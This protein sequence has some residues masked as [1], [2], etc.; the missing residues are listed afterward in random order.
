MKKLALI[1]FLTACYVFDPPSDAYHITR[2]AEYDAWWVEV[3]KCSG[4]T[5]D[6]NRVN[7]N[8][9]PPNDP[10]GFLR[11]GQYIDG[12]WLPTHMIYIGEFYQDSKLLVTHEMLHDLLQLPGQHP[13]EYFCGKC[14][15]VVGTSCTNGHYVGDDIMIEPITGI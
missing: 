10:R 8:L 4:I 5:G 7:Y 15:N 2:P 12:L 6:I 9:V 11:K 1:F 14:F 13:D 3:E